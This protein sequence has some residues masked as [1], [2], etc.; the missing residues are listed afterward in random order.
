MSGFNK[1]KLKREIERD[2]KAKVRARLR[3]IRA[4]IKAAR[5]R[6]KDEIALIREQCRAERKALSI[7]C[8]VRREEA[9]ELTRQTVKE[10]RQ[11]IHGIEGEERIYSEVDQR[12][13]VTKSK[14]VERRAESDDEV[15]G[16]LP[17]EFVPV[18]DQIK[19]KIKG[20]PRKTRTESFLH[21]VHENPGAVWEMRS[22]AADRDVEKLIREQQEL[23]RAERKRS[24][25]R[26]AVPF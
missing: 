12:G 21:W 22:G 16:N 25:R 10:K 3:E 26:E 15:R 6:R 1:A 18:F 23:E 2:R 13:R 4:L 19:R 14:A 20:S 17:A 7:R 9:Q 5:G 8:N 24:R 11:E